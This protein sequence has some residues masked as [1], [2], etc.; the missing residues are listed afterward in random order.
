MKL[1]AR[2]SSRFPGDWSDWRR[3]DKKDAVVIL[4]ILAL[5]YVVGTI[6]DWAIKLLQFAV[7]H[8]NWYI[9]DM[10]F[11]AFVLGLAMI[12]YGFR[13]Y[14]DISREI[15]GRITA[16][17]EARNL[18]RHDPLTGLPNRRFFAEKLDECLSHV[19]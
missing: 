4:G 10:L 19:H 12:V 11:M 16:E 2:L 7:D 14:K 18:A 9:D 1:A 17:S 5:T 3:R 13:R 8:Q 15:K 6:Y